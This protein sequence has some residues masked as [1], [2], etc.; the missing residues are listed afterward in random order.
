MK[1]VPLPVR[2]VL[3]LQG[4]PCPFFLRL[5]EELMNRG[6][7]VFRINLNGGDRRDWREGSTDYRCRPSDWPMYFDRFVRQHHVTDLVLYG[8]CR[9]MH[10]AAHRLA[11]LRGIRIHVFEEGYIRPDWMTL[12]RDGVNGHST[13]VRDPVSILEAARGLPPIPKLPPITASFRRRAHD[14]YWHYHYIVTGIVRFP[15]YRSH[16]Q[17]IIIGEGFG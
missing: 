1:P 13:L 14:S 15:F 9:P 8:D 7:G 16:R 10:M 2:V 6:M 4:P 11:R 12:E 3:F 17:G 5:G